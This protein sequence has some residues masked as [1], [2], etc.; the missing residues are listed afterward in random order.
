ML[1]SVPT[2]EP[3]PEPGGCDGAG[4]PE[5]VPGA[6]A[7][8]DAANQRRVDQ[9][10]GFA[11][12]VIAAAEKVCAVEERRTGSCDSSGRLRHLIQD[13]KGVVATREKEL[14]VRVNEPGAY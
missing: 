6:G 5:G 13:M 12:E 1:G 8:V 10:R 3:E 2:M 4:L 14:T 11:R 7:P 9:S